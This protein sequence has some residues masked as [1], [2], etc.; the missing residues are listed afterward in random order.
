MDSTNSLKKPSTQ[1]ADERGTLHP[2]HCSEAGNNDCLE[3]DVRLS[4]GEREG[5]E[6]G[7]KGIDHPS[8]DSGQ[9][10]EGPPAYGVWNEE[11]IHRMRS[12]WKSTD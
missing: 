4:N 11:T 9:R 1:M 7:R 8:G 6:E 5:G 2:S 10:N 3:S 12:V